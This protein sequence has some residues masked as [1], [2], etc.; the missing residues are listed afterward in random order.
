MKNNFI[1]KL[2]HKL[3]IHVKGK[4]INRFIKRLSDNKI[5]LLNINIINKNEVNIIVKEKD[6]NKIKDLKTV[7]DIS[8]IEVLGMLQVKKIINQNK[9]M[10]TIF[11]LGI[12]LL[13]FL[14]NIVFDVEVVHTNRELREYLIYELSQENIKPFQFKLNYQQLQKIKEKIINENKDRIEWLE[15]ENVGTKYIVRVEERRLPTPKIKPQNRHIVSKKSAIIKKIEAKSG[16]VIRE[17]NDYV[18]PGDIIISGQ[19]KLYDNIKSIIPAEGQVYG[20]VW[21]ETKVTYPLFKKEEKVLPSNKKVLVLQFLNKKIE[22]FNLKPYKNKKSNEKIII[23]SNL[24][25]L[26]LYMDNQQETEIVEEIITFDEAIS[27]AVEVGRR[28]I[29]EKLKRE[30]YIISQK[31]LKIDAKSSKM[32]VDIFFV[33]YEDITNY[34]EIKEE[35]EES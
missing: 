21:Y 19:I 15:I 13:I 28:K 26:I 5:E 6:F 35:T 3:L 23:K 29:E 12:F 20:E 34:Q 10:L 22:F 16:E 9:I 2:Q 32:I 8:I 4:N 24:L 1:N 7:Y 31:S 25:P 30:E 33:V 11:V 27:R 14:T 17:V 18:K